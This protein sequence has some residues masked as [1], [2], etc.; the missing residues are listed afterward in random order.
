MDVPH[1]ASLTVTRPYRQRETYPCRNTRGGLFEKIP[2]DLLVVRALSLT[3]LFL[4]A[5]PQRLRLLSHLLVHVLLALVVLV[6]ATRLQVQLVHAPVLQVVAE[7]QHAHL[8]D[9]M[10]FAR[11]VE[12]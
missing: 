7:R 1:A 9:Q 12:V 2:Q 6:L 3:E 8:V 10:Q 11:P 5:L 4:V